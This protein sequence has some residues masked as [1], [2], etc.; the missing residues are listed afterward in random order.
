[1]HRVEELSAKLSDSDALVIA[2]ASSIDMLLGEKSSLQQSLTATEAAVRTG[3]ERAAVVD[4]TNGRQAALIRQLQMD[5]AALEAQQGRALGNERDRSAAAQESLA[6]QLTESERQKGD[7]VNE[8][9]ER[10]R[11]MRIWQNEQSAVEAELREQSAAIM[12]RDKQID[13]LRMQNAALEGALAELRATNEAETPTP[14][15][16]ASP[17]P[18][19]TPIPMV[20]PAATAATQQRLSDLE[21]ANDALRGELSSGIAARQADTTM[22]NQ[23]LAAARADHDQTLQQLRA[24]E[25]NLKRAEEVHANEAS[26][27]KAKVES[28]P[29]ASLVDDH[30][31]LEAKIA[32][33]QTSLSTAQST[34]EEQANALKR[35][36]SSL[37]QQRAE[38]DE[39]RKRSVR[40][41]VSRFEDISDRERA[42]MLTP[43]PIPGRGRSGSIRKQSAS[44]PAPV[45][46][47]LRSRSNSGA[48]RSAAAAPVN[49]SVV[50]DNHGQQSTS[51]GAD[52]RGRADSHD[53]SQDGDHEGKVSDAVALA[54][55]PAVAAAIAEAHSATKRARHEREKSFADLQARL[56]AEAVTIAQW[57]EAATQATE[58]AEKATEDASNA[59]AQ[60]VLTQSTLADVEAKTAVQT[61][62]I[63]QLQRELN[64]LQGKL[65]ALTAVNARLVSTVD[66]ATSHLERIA[67]QEATIARLEE[68][69]TTSH[70]E[71]MEQLKQISDIQQEANAAHEQVN[72]LQQQLENSNK[73]LENANKSLGDKQHAIDNNKKAAADAMI[74]KDN[75]D[76]EVKR[77]N[78]ELN[79]LKESLAKL[80]DDHQNQQDKNNTL[81][82]SIDQLKADK[83][84][85]NDTIGQLHQQMEDSNRDNDQL[86]KQLSDNTV[87][88]ERVIQA[89]KRDHNAS[90]AQQ[91]DTI[92]RLIDQVA[93]L[94]SKLKDQD[95]TIKQ[96]KDGMTNSNDEKELTLADQNRIVEDLRQ[97]IANLTKQV[98]DLRHDN[99]QLKAD[100][101]KAADVRT[102]LEKRI[103]ELESLLKESSDREAK[104]QSE[105]GR[106]NE[107][108]DHAHK[109]MASAHGLSELNAELQAEKIMLEKRLTDRQRGDQTA[110]ADFGVKLASLEAQK[111][112][113]TNEKNGLESQLEDERRASAAA[114]ADISR[115]QEEQRLI[116]ATRKALPPTPVA[117]SA[118][119]A[120]PEEVSSLNKQIN[121]LSADITQLTAD[122]QKLAES[123]SQLEASARE[124]KRTHDDHDNKER[125]STAAIDRLVDQ[126][127][128]LQQK[129]KEASVQSSPSGGNAAAPNAD[130]VNELEQKVRQLTADNERLVS[131][132]K[133]GTKDRQRANDVQAALDDT[134]TKLRTLESDNERLVNA[135]REHTADRQRAN[136]QQQAADKLR[137]ELADVAGRLTTLQSENDTIQQQLRDALSANEIAL[138][139]ANGTITNLQTELAAARSA[140]LSVNTNIGHV[141]PSPLS[142]SPA[143]KKSSGPVAAAVAAAEA[144]NESSRPP[145]M[146]RSGSRSSLD[147]NAADPTAVIAS[148]AATIERLRLE[149]ADLQQRLRALQP[150]T[151]GGTYGG[152][153]HDAEVQR[154]EAELEKQKAETEQW[155]K[156]SVKEMVNKFE[157]ISAKERETMQ[158]KKKVDPRTV[159]ELQ[160]SR[161]LLATQVAGLRGALLASNAVPRVAGNAALSNTMGGVRGRTASLIVPATSSTATRTVVNQTKPP[162]HATTV[163]PGVGGVRN[164]GTPLPAG[165]AAKMAAAVVTAASSPLKPAGGSVAAVPTA[166]PSTNVPAKQQQ[167]QQQQQQQSPSLTATAPHSTGR[168]ASGTPSSLAPPP[169]VLS[170]LGSSSTHTPPTI[171]LRMISPPG[172]VKTGPQSPATPHTPM[173]RALPPPLVILPITYSSGGPPSPAD[174]AVV[175][176]PNV[177]RA[178]LVLE[179]KTSI[180]DP[181]HAGIPTTPLQLLSGPSSSGQGGPMSSRHVVRGD[182]ER[183]NSGVEGGKVMMPEGPDSVRSPTRALSPERAVAYPIGYDA[184][185]PQQIA[186]A[187]PTSPPQLT[188]MS[189]TS[190]MVLQPLEATLLS[191]GL[192]DG[193]FEYQLEELMLMEEMEVVMEDMPIEMQDGSDDANPTGGDGNQPA[194]AS[195]GTVPGAASVEALEKAVDAL[196]KQKETLQA[197]VVAH[198]ARD[199]AILRATVPSAEAVDRQRMEE[200]LA[201]LEKRATAAVRE[202]KLAHE[203]AALAEMGRNQ[204]QQELASLKEQ[205]NAGGGAATGGSGTV[206]PSHNRVPSIE[207]KGFNNNNT[208]P[209]PIIKPKPRHGSADLGDK[210]VAAQAAVSMLQKEKALLASQIANS[211]ATKDAKESETARQAAE[212]R[213]AE[214]AKALED[215]RQGRADS[216]KYITDLEADRTKLIS[217]ADGLAAELDR[218]YATQPQQGGSTGGGNTNIGGTHTPRRGSSLGVPTIIT[219][220]PHHSNNGWSSGRASPSPDQGGSGVMDTQTRGQLHKAVAGLLHDK[221]ASEALREQVAQLQSEQKERDDRIDQMTN[222]LQRARD[223]LQAERDRIQPKVEH[224]ANH[225]AGLEAVVAQLQ[226]A[227]HGELPVPSD[228]RPLPDIMNALRSAPPLGSSA[229]GVPLKDAASSPIATSTSPNAFDAASS[230]PPPVARKSATHIDDIIMGDPYSKT[231]AQRVKIRIDTDHARV[232]SLYDRAAFEVKFVGD[233]ADA[234]KCDR[235]RFT[236]INVERGSVVVTLQIEAGDPSAMAMALQLRKLLGPCCTL[237][238]MELTLAPAKDAPKDGK[239]A[240]TST[241]ANH[242]GDDETPGSSGDS[243]R[244]AAK[245]T[246]GLKSGAGVKNDNP[247]DDESKAAQAKTAAMVKEN[248]RLRQ[249]LTDAQAQVAATDAALTDA[250]AK[251]ADARDT[252]Q[253]LAAARRA[254]DELTQQVAAAEAK[255]TQATNKLKDADAKVAAAETKA[256]DAEAKLATAQDKLAEAEHKIV[257]HEAAIDE[258]HRGADRSSSTSDKTIADLRD[259]LRQARE[260]ASDAMKRT[261]ALEQGRS[262]ADQARIAALTAHELAVVEM[263][264]AATNATDAKGAL[265]EAEASLALKDATIERINSEL[266]ELQAKLKALTSVNQRLSATSDDLKAQN[267]A[268]KDEQATLGE[269][270]A[271]IGPDLEQLESL[272]SA[273][274]QSS[275][276]IRG[277]EKKLAEAEARANGRLTEQQRNHDKDREALEAQIASLQTSMASNE[278]VMHDADGQ[279]ALLMK[280]HKAQGDQLLAADSKAADL[281]VALDRARTAA[282]EQTRLITQL[283]SDNARLNATS[284]ER[285]RTIEQLSN[286]KHQLEASIR[287]NESLRPLLQEQITAN[288]ALQQQS[289]TDRQLAERLQ[290][291]HNTLQAEL[292]ALHTKVAE[293]ARQT[294]LNEASLEQQQR[295]ERQLVDSEARLKAAIDELDGPLRSDGSR[296]PNGLRQQRND[297]DN[298]LSSLRRERDSLLQAAEQQQAQM[299]TRAAE[300]DNERNARLR[301]L[302]EENNSLHAELRLLGQAIAAGDASR[303]LPSPG[304]AGASS[305][306]L[307]L[308]APGTTNDPPVGSGPLLDRINELE[309]SRRELQRQND[310]LSSL[311][312]RHQLTSQQLE[313]RL[314]GTTAD[315]A[316]AHTKIG[317][318]SEALLQL[319]RT[320]DQMQNALE[321]EDR[322]KLSIT[323]APADRDAPLPLGVPASITSLRDKLSTLNRTVAQPNVD[324]GR[325][326]MTQIADIQRSIDNAIRQLQDRINTLERD[327]GMLLDMERTRR[328]D[329]RDRIPPPPSLADEPTLVSR[330]MR[331]KAALEAKVSSLQTKLDNASSRPGSAATTPRGSQV[332]QSFRTSGAKKPGT[333][334]AA[335]ANVSHPNNLADWNVRD[336]RARITQLEGE[337]RQLQDQ[338][339]AIPLPAERDDRGENEL[340]AKYQQL[341]SDNE[342]LESKLEAFQ[343]RI[344]DLES[345]L[346]TALASP[347]TSVSN[348]HNDDIVR[349]LQKRLHEANGDNIALRDRL[350]SVTHEHRQRVA[351]LHRAAEEQ[352]T[353]ELDNLQIIHQ[354]TNTITSLETTIERLHH[355]I[356][357]GGLVPMT[358]APSIRDDTSS[359]RG[360]AP[361][362]AGRRQVPS[363]SRDTSPP[364]SSQGDVLSRLELLQSSMQ[365]QITQLQHDKADLESRLRQALRDMAQ[366][367][368]VIDTLQ[369]ATPLPPSSSVWPS[370]DKT[371]T[372]SRALVSTNNGNNTL[373]LAALEELE[374]QH[375]AVE[376]DK[377][378]LQQS[379]DAQSAELDN[380]RRTIAQLREDNVG[381]GTTAPLPRNGGLSLSDLADLRATIS[382]QQALLEEQAQAADQHHVDMTDLRSTLAQLRATNAELTAR[383]GDLETQLRNRSST[384]TATNSNVVDANARLRR[385]EAA[386]AELEE[387]LASRQQQVS[388]LQS[389]LDAAAR[390]TQRAEDAAKKNASSASLA[391]EAK[392]LTAENTSLS[393]RLHN[394]DD[395]NRRLIAD[396]DTLTQQLQSTQHEL[397][398]LQTRMR[399]ADTKV[400]AAE[401]KAANAIAAAVAAS[402]AAPSRGSSTSQ[403]GRLS[404]VN[405]QDND[406][407]AQLQREQDDLLAKWAEAVAIHRRHV[408]ELNGENH[409]LGDTHQSLRHTVAHQARLFTELER[410]FGPSNGSS[411]QS[412]LMPPSTRALGHDV[413]PTSVSMSAAVPESPLM[414]PAVSNVAQVHAPHTAPGYALRNGHPRAAAAAT[415]PLDVD[416]DLHAS[417]PSHIVDDGYDD[418]HGYT[419][420][421]VPASGLVSPSPQPSSTMSASGVSRPR[422][423]VNQTLLRRE[424]K[425][426]QNGGQA[427]SA[428]SSPRSVSSTRSATTSGNVDGKRMSTQSQS[429]VPPSSAP[430]QSHSPPQ[431]GSTTS[432]SIPPPWQP[433]QSV[434]ATSSVV[435]TGGIRSRSSSTTSIATRS[436]S[437]AQMTSTTPSL[438]IVP[439]YTNMSNDL[440]QIEQRLRTLLGM[441]DPRH[442]GNIHIISYS[443]FSCCHY[444]LRFDHIAEVRAL[445]AQYQR[446]IDARDPSRRPV[447]LAGSYS[448]TRFLCECSCLQ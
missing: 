264:K 392:A 403:P 315:L 441:E 67:A 120:S 432:Q 163:N 46:S 282:T 28:L 156:R 61:A 49:V 35:L 339:Q 289:R 447:F 311:C 16:Q 369:P 218:Y 30:K 234:L 69:A 304:A 173:E 434:A 21:R 205:K 193:A 297:L 42:S 177:R 11:I 260:D 219:I 99:E 172:E 32:G 4:D 442:D 81:Q 55:E 198:L 170:P 114:K 206:P 220:D 56:E 410:S 354:H 143:S 231:A 41:M 78:D 230:P 159:A 280:K 246:K 365:S 368:A 326:A 370:V 77:L 244:A 257:K 319:Q 349:S 348:I 158:P 197:L 137:G 420:P 146:V 334:S 446:L 386:R 73:Q 402:S 229:S 352:G 233:L 374:R 48:D 267:A 178:P 7:L 294:A 54:A 179:L 255:A 34:I 82:S 343:R 430:S 308:P 63:E 405:L 209:S 124:S 135:T 102:Q 176:S 87:E 377:H 20:D 17:S 439:A 252:K 301:D 43:P 112:A 266:A 27:V 88:H 12:D 103:S 345:R 307:P 212:K 1:L 364:M 415:A 19:L 84:K 290:A 13:T 186:A 407:I 38:N 154:L 8:I 353:K 140:A 101:I 203:R 147:L 150:T 286:D 74:A 278:Q 160:T 438:S 433:T 400:A 309:K 250:L 199:N 157:D 425:H 25:A 385:S 312:D 251:V 122:K 126:V 183:R 181:D 76:D 237:V 125:E 200:M 106:T 36:Q 164:E 416:D 144:V 419:L 3:Q 10:D 411:Q 276:R 168:R 248:D 287:D 351:E 395:H 279:V 332:P 358:S 240:S 338:L 268:L 305:T 399:H 80:R 283:Q 145:R 148:Q 57:Q 381:G 382:E 409:T 242:D 383:I 108:L 306:P 228:S 423:G 175:S 428:R 207:S 359:A 443:N 149:V 118:P 424:E 313:L 31:Q 380:M 221:V 60:L 314:N 390:H 227:Q 68:E 94:Q 58:A 271:A 52:K 333:A 241:D 153:L 320:I 254:T 91:T 429:R 98:E 223:E 299:R 435:P 29:P 414:S 253:Q 413:A 130:E 384:T 119:G 131:L 15:P 104:L 396:H 70:T 327:K 97:Q 347:S 291:E 375:R 317:A 284:A 162:L 389:A 445:L 2:Q 128:K 187:N 298:T 342:V 346:A 269:Q 356:T 167:Q 23:Q 421:R 6:S 201:D 194:V 427:G 303:P 376:A 408:E 169:S 96:L 344:H 50:I 138:R 71:N 261:K 367:A 180:A 142:P 378:A 216:E 310:A 190:Y 72:Q 51:G 59:N 321:E 272:K 371:A 90:G 226:A 174:L 18:P 225:V 426:I 302:Q 404:G 355:Q 191:V 300:M 107:A 152:P 53:N 213:V 111:A 316:A 192:A 262:T 330:L 366:Q 64:D 222:E 431:R 215:E 224:V 204:A 440:N 249:G 117:A 139:D 329:E 448:M 93:T 14:V 436:S 22:W 245:Q 195:S 171:D 296:A 5:K 372:T 37:D 115:L 394:S 391:A 361:S 247:E 26:A 86:K 281:Q 328:S 324:N 323:E 239:S 136:E 40:E 295:L 65:R 263:N 277:L 165:V 258:A 188:L 127:A 325:R 270:L 39:W 401:S 129:L 79:R 121:D 341:L 273:A 132:V 274:N 83:E 66:D 393:N 62:T 141:A 444:S 362:A 236:I 418:A 350:T 214:L 265:A 331:E 293:Q 45:P 336:L 134:L 166:S 182:F 161:R 105:L 417:A 33:L 123:I 373:S 340:E 398:Q 196:A 235:N 116:A 243:K 335:S 357:Q 437:N 185:S 85:A 285:G 238:P 211:A 275:D 379:V 100:A 337:K 322:A 232:A 412:R 256:R 208:P 202:A 189:P 9:G 210:L 388:S 89:A 151:E 292:K 387:Q 44:P 184:R 422:A 155:R 288:N 133:D 75:A 259:Q 24:T 217:E 360:S 113:L 92:D 397:H 47:G 363:S 95:G 406:R 318:Q 109:E 110:A